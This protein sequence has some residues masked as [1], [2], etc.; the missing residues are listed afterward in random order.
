VHVTGD[1]TSHWVAKTIGGH[2]VEWDAQIVEDQQNE[3][4]RWRAVGDADIRHAGLVTFRPAPGDRGTEMRVML[5]YAPP[6]GPLTAAMASLFGKEPAQQIRDDLRR[7]KQMME[8]REVPTTA[9]QP[10][11]RG[12]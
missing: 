11:G 4:I 6:G 9:G 7:F 12:R 8:A 10:A 3:R 5:E 2:R 1:H